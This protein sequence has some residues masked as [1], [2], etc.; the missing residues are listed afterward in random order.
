MSNPAR[1]ECPI[2]RTCDSSACGRQSC[3]T[4]RHRPEGRESQ[5]A[6]STLAFF[7][8]EP[9]GTAV[10]FSVV[11]KNFT[12]LVSDRRF[13]GGPVRAQRRRKE[14]PCRHNNNNNK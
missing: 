6:A 4:K 11:A 7:D 8:L 13:C 9:I 2:R 10:A 1:C 14:R 12:Q 5:K 3:R